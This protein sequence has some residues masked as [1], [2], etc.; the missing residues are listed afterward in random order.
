VSVLAAAAAAAAAAAPPPLTRLCSIT[1]R[2]WHEPRGPTH[3]RSSSLFKQVQ[4]PLPLSSLQSATVVSQLG[5]S[6]KSKLPTL[7]PAA[8]YSRSLKV[9]FPDRTLILT[10]DSAD[11]ANEIVQGVYDLSKK[12]KSR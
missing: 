10:A 1:C 2:Y 9:T 6:D 7:M 8:D 11:E 12:S 3:K 5:P 4:E